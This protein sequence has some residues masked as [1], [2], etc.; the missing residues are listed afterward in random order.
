MRRILG[1]TLGCIG[2]VATAASAQVTI[3]APQGTVSVASAND[4]A[5]Q[6]FQD[7]W[8]MSERTDPGWWI[9]SIDTPSHGF[10]SIN[11]NGGIFSGTVAADPNIWLLETGLPNLPAIGKTGKTYPINANVYR[12]LAVRM[13]LDQPEYMM[14]QWST[15]T[16]YEP[17]GLQA[18][19]IVPTSAGWRI[20][21]VDLATLPMLVGS[22]TWAGWKRSLR[23]DPAP[24]NSPAGSKI[25]V[26]WVRLVDNQPGLYR[27]ITWNNP[28]WNVD[29]YLDNGTNAGSDANSTLGLIA[30]NV[31][32]TSYSL[33]VGALQPGDYYVAMR[34][35][36]TTGAFSYSPGFFRVNAPATLT[37]T[38][39]SEEGS[40]DD[41]ATTHLNNP[42]DMNAAS[43]I[44][45]TIN[46]TGA[47]VGAVGVENEAG[48][49][50]G[51]VNAFV[52]ASTTGEFSQAPCASFAKPV[53]YPFHANV[54]GF[55]RRIDPDRYRILTL[56]MGLPNKP[57]DLCGGSIV[58]VVW[59]V[60]GD[61]Q[62]TYSWG[63]ALNS[64]AGANVLDKFN[65][66]MKALPIDPS[67]PSQTGWVPG[68]SS[69]PGIASFRI[70]PHEFVNPT[71][72]YIKRIK[73]AALETSHT[74]YTVQWTTS[75]TGGTINVYYDTDK[76]PSQKT[77]IGQAAASSTSGSMNWNTTSLPQGA[78]YYI[79][80]EQN[81][82][83]NVNGTYSKWPIEIDHSP[84]NNVRLVLN[85]TR[86]NFGATA[87]TIKT[88]A[89]TVRLTTLNGSP[90]WTATSDQPFIQITPASGCGGATLSVSLV[91]QAYNG[92]ADYLGLIRITSQ[93]A[94]NSPQFIE[95][96]LRIR[97]ATGPPSGFVDT[98][99]NGAAVK[100]S[101]AVT[102][103]AID[104]VGVARVTICRDPVSGE[105]GNHPLC[106]PG[107]IY[108]GDAVMIDD[109][110]PDLEAASP[111]TPL[112]YRAGWGFLVLTNTLP[113]QG[114]GPFTLHIHAFDIEGHRAALGSRAIVGQNS[115]ATEPF[116]TIDT[117]GQGE[118]VGGSTYANYGWV[119]SRVRRADPPGGGVVTV[120]ID[121]VAVGSPCCWNSRADLT[122]TF[123]GFPGVNNALGVF[124]FNTQAYSNGLHTIVWVVT[125]NAGVSSGVGSRFFSIFNAGGSLTASAMRPVGPDLGKH[126]D[127]LVAGMGAAPIKVREGFRL[128]G[129]M[130]NIDKGLSA[131]RHV[132]ATERDRLEIQLASAGA[133]EY[134]GYLMVGGRLRELPNGSSFDPARGAFYWQPGLG[135]IGDYDLLFVKTRADGVRERVPVRV[136]LQERQAELADATTKL[137]SIWTRV[138]F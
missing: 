57:R 61:A 131:T 64:R 12:I 110:R 74:Q 104:D 63:I 118:T 122:G 35:T 14:F 20:Y 39:P 93:D 132:W 8:D 94:I 124:G 48:Q 11:F 137:G 56:E 123:P 80:V 101:V 38:A 67:S 79:F 83:V 47:G 25:D 60:A 24:D 89:Q 1:F 100:G 135:Y 49:Q 26:D 16:I 87:Q 130:Q 21:F 34:R 45:W 58:R 75:K 17:P 88:P 136:T 138:A 28:G 19:G 15:N 72:F 43:D 23:M 42:W 134:A 70:D 33:N 2:L 55:Y 77:L 52:G 78:Q 68:V 113:N 36:G 53:V 27:N 10:S 46:V 66:D 120:Y 115:S 107:Q 54:R 32:G 76:D 111:T 30:S 114:N 62:E 31:S 119:L 65:L 71:S 4:F 22:D 40:A 41:F 85:R 9:H 106:A 82:G 102:G 7:P 127:D 95:T 73:L 86:L 29:I 90:C 91:N 126:V 125:D 117:P 97:V 6:T 13:R 129:P 96:A 112:N 3:T 99:A 81:D 116:G 121:G 108:I 98:P 5:T 50:L 133:G 105:V 44:D 51:G 84:P 109:A 37:I 59:Q 103:W 92:Q 128:T 69:N 18:A